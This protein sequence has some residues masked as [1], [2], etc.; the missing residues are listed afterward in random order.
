MGRGS[1]AVFPELDGLA[2]S[3]PTQDCPP[4]AFASQ[5]SA[6]GIMGP[7]RL[8]SGKRP[9]SL[10]LWLDQQQPSA[11]QTQADY[12]AQAFPP[13]ALSPPSTSTSTQQQT[14]AASVFPRRPLEHDEPWHG[15]FALPENVRP[16]QRMG[17]QENYSRLVGRSMHYRDPAPSDLDR[18]ET[19][20]PPSDSG[21]HTKSRATTSVVSRRTSVIGSDA[22]GLFNR[23]DDDESAQPPGDLQLGLQALG[24][25]GRVNGPSSRSRVPRPCPV[26]GVQLSKHSEVKKHKARHE[27][28]FKCGDP[29]CA[30]SI[31]GFP[32]ANDRNR[33]MIK[34]DRTK[35]QK[36]WQCPFPDCKSAGKI[37]ARLDNFRV[38]VKNRHKSDNVD[39]VLQ[40][41]EICQSKASTED[42]PKAVDRAKVASSNVGKEATDQHPTDA[43]LRDICPGETQQPLFPIHGDLGRT[44]DRET[45]LRPSATSDAAGILVG[46]STSILP[47]DHA[48]DARRS[49][50]EIERVEARASVRINNVDEDDEPAQTVWNGCDGSEQSPLQAEPSSRIIEMAGGNG[51]GSRTRLPPTPVADTQ[52]TGDGPQLEK[53]QDIATVL[54]QLT[55]VTAHMKQL[56]DSKEENQGQV[57]VLPGSADV[58]RRDGPGSKAASTRPGHTLGRDAIVGSATKPISV[59]GA[60]QES[61][62]KEGKAQVEG[63]LQELLQLCKRL[64]GPLV[65][66]ANVS[67]DS[68]GE[69]LEPCPECFKKIKKGSFGK[70]LLRHKKVWGCTF[71]ECNQES[72]G[73]KSD[74]KRHEN[75][76]HFQIETFLCNQN[77]A[78]TGGKPCMKRFYRRE[79]FQHHLRQHH[80]MANP[81]DLRRK[82]QEQRI[83]RSG[84]VRF[85]CGFCEKTVSLKSSGTKA[86]DERFDHIDHHL[87]EK[88]YTMGDWLATNGKRLRERSKWGGTSPNTAGDSEHD[89]R[90]EDSSKS[91]S[92][93]RQARSRAG[94]GENGDAD[95]PVDRLS[96][97]AGGAGRKRRAQTDSG[98]DLRAVKGARQSEVV[99]EEKEDREEGDEG[100]SSQPGR[101]STWY[102]CQCGN[103]PHNYH[104]EKVCRQDGNPPCAGHRWCPECKTQEEDDEGDLYDGAIL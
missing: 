28:A 58:G 23:A 92:T 46:L 57:P 95:S 65:T 88:Q 13:M 80:N 74:W 62:D 104:L 16:D 21:Y 83:G 100:V 63:T 20:P 51:D 72:F 32:N 60:G 11:Y 81:E 10:D 1:D 49:I 7:P 61:R 64:N 79:K 55:M 48:N 98:D 70:H 8:R 34:H 56:L 82:A 44:D 89:S 43:D 2:S 47:H 18:T 75:S 50:M 41:A 68:I 38:H 77:D 15:I 40:R 35:A 30:R 103:G 31:D 19:N 101:G 4:D 76:Q 73:S 17:H 9:Q 6:N 84:Q 86:W 26:C 90:A 87:R 39:A 33:H 5:S 94:S 69:E 67:R 54:Q 45:V 53:G 78:G 42:H 27:K 85:W 66:G 37:W 91:V 24:I 59:E 29:T 71:F 102:C 3:V 36:V 14:E 97:R 99:V 22:Q 96:D 12:Q 93:E 25:E 52:S